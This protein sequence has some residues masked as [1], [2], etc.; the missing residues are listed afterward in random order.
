MPASKTHKLKERASVAASAAFASVMLACTGLHLEWA[1]G[2]ALIGLGRHQLS[3]LH[4]DLDWLWRVRWSGW[5]CLRRAVHSGA[6]AP[7][8][9]HD[10]NDWAGLSPH[11]GRPTTRSATTLTGPGSLASNRCPSSSPLA[12][13]A[14]AAG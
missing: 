12:S 2:Q 13:A 6:I 4:L 14:V 3:R 7:S 9:A 10:E 5:R 8:S 1:D 11:A